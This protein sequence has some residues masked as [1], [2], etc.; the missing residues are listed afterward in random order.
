MYIPKFIISGLLVCLAM[1]GWARPVTAEQALRQ[2][3][4]FYESKEVF[5]GRFTRSLSVE[6][7]F[8]VAYMA[9]R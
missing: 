6:P 9:C 7:R 5:G 4:D 8:D 3:R 2:A 1:A